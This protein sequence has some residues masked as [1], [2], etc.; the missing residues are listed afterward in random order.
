MSAEGG[1]SRL[2]GMTAYSVRMEHLEWFV[3][4]GAPH[5][6]HAEVAAEPYTEAE[7]AEALAK[8][9]GRVTAEAL[10]RGRPP[11]NWWDIPRENS[12][13]KERQYGPPHHPSMKPL[14]I[15]KRIVEVRVVCMRP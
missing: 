14:A 8:G 12:R 1:D 10:A 3:K 7:A 13:S 2:K 15:C 4:P 5:T 9:V 6:F 11:R